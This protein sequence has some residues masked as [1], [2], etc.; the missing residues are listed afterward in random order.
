MTAS[1]RHRLRRS[2]ATDFPFLEEIL[3][4][5]FFRDPAGSRTLL[6]PLQ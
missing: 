2:D 6:R 4:E 3:F 1:T 5:A